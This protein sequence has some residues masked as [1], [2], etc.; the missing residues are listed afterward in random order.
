[1]FSFILT[2]DEKIQ[3]HMQDLIAALKAGELARHEQEKLSSAMDVRKLLSIDHLIYYQ[4][5]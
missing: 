2:I 1:M 4:L 5:C 3:M